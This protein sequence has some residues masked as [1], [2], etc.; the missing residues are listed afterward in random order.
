MTTNQPSQ[1]ELSKC[2]DREKCSFTQLKPETWRAASFSDRNMG[3]ENLSTIWPKGHCLNSAKHRPLTAWNHTWAEMQIS[4]R[5]P[6]YE[7]LSDISFNGSRT[8]RV[9]LVKKKHY[10]NLVPRFSLLPVE[11]P[12]LGLITCLSESGLSGKCRVRSAE[13]GVWKMWSVEN[14]ECGKCGAWQLEK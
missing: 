8:Q 3:R 4:F 9:G 7:A 13:C 1:T 14:A 6:S 5:N 11:R 2:H 12:W 10:P